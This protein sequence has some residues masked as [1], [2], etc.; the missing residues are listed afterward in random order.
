MLYDLEKDFRAKAAV[1]EVVTAVLEVEAPIEANRFARAVCRAFDFG[2]MT[3]DRSE[4][5]VGLVPEGLVHTD[6]VGRFIWREERQWENW[7]R[8]RTSNGDPSKKPF[9][10]RK[11]EEVSAFEYQNA[12]VDFVQ[13]SHSMT[14]D[15]LVVELARCFGTRRVYDPTK[16]MIR[17]VL[18][19]AVQKGLVKFDGDMYAPT[20]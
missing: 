11:P 4:Q 14:Q 8:Y 12:L 1:M 15:D 2:R 20:N 19:D 16:L 3:P 18:D 10:T 5:I 13:R 9:E 17:T 7:T 6:V